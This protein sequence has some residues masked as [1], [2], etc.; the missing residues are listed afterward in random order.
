MDGNKL[1]LAWSALPW[2]RWARWGWGAL[3]GGTCQMQAGWLIAMIWK[4]LRESNSALSSKLSHFL[5]FSLELVKPLNIFTVS[6]LLFILTDSF[7]IFLLFESNVLIICSTVYLRQHCFLKKIT[8]PLCFDDEDVPLADGRLFW[9]ERDWIVLP[10]FC[11]S[12][13]LT[14]EWRVIAPFLSLPFL[15]YKHRPRIRTIK[16]LNYFSVSPHSFHLWIPL[17]THPYPRPSSSFSSPSS[18]PPSVLP[19]FLVCPSLS[20]GLL[21][22]MG[23]AE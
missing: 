3:R 18:L 4:V 16:I 1:A 14:H 5:C 9:W 11:Q 2:V 13:S 19:I 20:A 17:S 21:A 23:C 6:C 15:V 8:L 22:G 12:F 10:C 7:G